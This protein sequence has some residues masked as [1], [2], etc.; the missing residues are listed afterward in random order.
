MPSSTR[1]IGIVLMTYGSATEA[2][3]V[4]PY[5]A[6]IYKN[7]VP[8]G[9]V[10]DFEERYRLV[11]GSP[12]VRITAEQA[13]LLEKALGEGFIVRSAMLHSAPFIDDVVADL[14][15]A[16]AEE[17]RGVILSPQLS[18]F[19]MDGYGITL[20]HAAE[21]N[22]FTADRVS[23]MPSWPTEPHFIKLLAQ[24]VRESLAAL[25]KKYQRKVPV[26][27]TTHSLPQRVVEK[28]PN[29]LDE[30]Q[31]TIAA[32]LEELQDSEL[33]YYSC[34]QSA[35]HTPEAWLKPDMTDILSML[36]DNGEPA[37]LIAPIQFLADHLE[38][39]YDL[40]IAAK[41]QCDDFGISYNRIELPNAHP[42]F[43]EALAGLTTQ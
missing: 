31:Q 35:G 39:L 16:G 5:M 37:V 17:I 15:Q 11:G 6:H 25:E 27:F 33:E 42:L 12:L 26:L 23:V 13:A 18:S 24:R 9:V 43:I 20:R 4:A 38:I 34:Y 21:K 29:Y 32:V 1:K 8:D 3:G 28:D 30:L 19:I 10:A 2:S 14:K 40:D 22:G 36:R 41:Q 7:G